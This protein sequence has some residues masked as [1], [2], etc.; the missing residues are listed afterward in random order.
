MSKR[1]EGIGSYTNQFA[2][3]PN[4]TQDLS[5]NAH[6]IYVG[7]AGAFKVTPTG[8]SVAVVYA[9]ALAGTIYKVSAKRVWAYSTSA[10]T[11]LVGLR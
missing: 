10:A 8:T 7:G 9:G 1:Y 2:I 3:T 5:Q 6:A 11:N 4:S